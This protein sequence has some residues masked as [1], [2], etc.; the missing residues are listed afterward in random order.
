MRWTGGAVLALALGGCT[1]EAAKDEDTDAAVVDTCP[2]AGC[3][4][5][6]ADDTD[7][8]G[9]TPLPDVA[10]VV[11]DTRRVLDGEPEATAEEEA[12]FASNRSML[13]YLLPTH[14]RTRLADDSP[15]EPE[16]DS[17]TGAP[18]GECEDSAVAAPASTTPYT[19]PELLEA[20]SPH[21]DLARTTNWSTQSAALA[22]SGVGVALK[23]GGEAWGGGFMPATLCTPDFDTP[24]ESLYF[25][26]AWFGGT[27]F[28]AP[29]NAFDTDG[30]KS[31]AD[32]P[33]E[34]AAADAFLA[35]VQAHIP[36][37]LPFH[38]DTVELGNGWFYDSGPHHRGLDYS[39]V[40]RT[41]GQDPGFEVVASADGIVRRVILMNEGGGNIVIIEHPRPDGKDLW[42]LY[43]HLRNGKA[44]DQAAAKA[45]TS[46]KS[47]KEC[48]AYAKFADDPDYANHPSWGTDYHYLRVKEG[49]LVRRG[50][51]I[52]WAG[53]TGC[54]GI[55]AGLTDEGKLTDE[56]LANTHLH[57]YYAMSMPGVTSNN[58]DG[59]TSQ[60]AVWIDPYGVYDKADD[61]GCYDVGMETPYPRLLA[62]FEPVFTDVPQQ[63]LGQYLGYYHDM[64]YGPRSISTT[65]L[66]GEI[67]THGV[68]APMAQGTWAVITNMDD[69]YL[70]GAKATQAAAGRRLE[71]L[72]VAYN[73]SARRW[74]GIWRTEGDQESDPHEPALTEQ[75]Y[76]QSWSTH[77]S[78]GGGM[79]RDYDSHGQG[80]GARISA[81]YLRPGESF[82]FFRERERN[83]M[84]Q[85]VD[86]QDD[87]DFKPLSVSVNPDTLAYSVVFVRDERETFYAAGIRAY[88]V[89]LVDGTLR[90]AGYRPQTLTG[91]VKDGETLYAGTWLKPAGPGLQQGFKLKK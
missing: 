51:L 48:K 30:D 27:R 53:H 5:D 82:V 29:N 74:A 64:A 72:Q 60:V 67:L 1:P 32:D 20:Q 40:G 8:V 31:L 22:M 50:D 47:S 78:G 71:Q 39:A 54:G 62:P 66:D 73:G 61:R 45:M 26:S 37:T 75:A 85:L 14:R 13:L 18:T 21:I 86:D 41:E 77:V 63:I 24:R 79:I 83:L 49:D 28:R 7:A 16:L 59:T 70:A 52:G 25:G 84:S 57:M 3:D 19:G 38:D 68:F 65:Y 69:A 12:R 15:C 11:P 55:G 58:A 76:F 88:A 90:E 33:A 36:F 46:G 80:A 6:P 87:K 23:E 34:L 42:S 81:L 91:Y 9:E 4:T 56:V 10:G 35:S 44:A 89:H 2:A 43:M 17:S